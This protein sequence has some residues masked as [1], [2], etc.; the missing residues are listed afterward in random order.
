VVIIKQRVRVQVHSE[1]VVVSKPF[2]GATGGFGL[3]NYTKATS[4][5]GSGGI[6]DDT[7][8]GGGFGGGD[9]FG[10]ASFDVNKYEFKN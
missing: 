8:F 5:F 4:T 6:A 1:V 7:T 9:T 2:G 3:A 10:G